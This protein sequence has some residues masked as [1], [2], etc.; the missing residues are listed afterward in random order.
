M[1]P[2]QHWDGWLRGKPAEAWMLPFPPGLLVARSVNPKVG[3]VRNNGPEL[4]AG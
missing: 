2:R 3:I 1:L 4:L